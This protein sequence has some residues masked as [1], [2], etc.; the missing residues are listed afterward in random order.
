VEQAP[1]FNPG[2]RI[3]EIDVGVLI[4]GVL[5]SVMVGR[6][7]SSLALAVAFTVAHFFYFCNILRM[8]RVLELGWAFLFTVLAGSTLVAG[9][10]TWNET[11]LL[12]LA[13][14]A[15]L[16]VLQVRT[17]SYH[18]VLWKRLNPELPQ[19]WAA[20]QRSSK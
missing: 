17:P 10:P 7:D 20:N 14:T 9:R 11:F 8:A 2:F 19:W 12:M 6:W 16:S 18:G 5:I 4:L 1:E 15:I 13:M 3:S